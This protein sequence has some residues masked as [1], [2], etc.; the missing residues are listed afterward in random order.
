VNVDISQD[1]PGPSSRRIAVLVVEDETLIR[2]LA[3]DSLQDAGFEVIA[4]V[5][6]A[7]A[8]A[9]LESNARIDFVFTDIMMPGSMNGIELG[10]WIRARRPDLPIAFTSGVA[11]ASMLTLG[12]RDGEAFFAKP[13]PFDG[14]IRHIRATLATA[15]AAAAT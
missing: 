1:S 5:N 12:L 8:I 10:A 9:I 6:A 15:H 4:A 3:M 11:R 14:L 2:M 13:V 7:E